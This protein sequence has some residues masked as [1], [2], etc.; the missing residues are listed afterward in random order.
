MPNVCRSREPCTLFCRVLCSAEELLQRFWRLTW[1]RLG[2][3]VED[4]I[5]LASPLHQSCTEILLI[6]QN[7]VDH[8]RPRREAS[9][10]AR[11]FLMYLLPPLP[12]HSHWRSCLAHPSRN[13]SLPGKGSRVGLCIVLFDA[14]RRSFTLIPASFAFVVASRRSSVV[15]IRIQFFADVPRRRASRTANSGDRA[16]FSWS[17]SDTDRRLTPSR[18]AS[19]V[20]VIGECGQHLLAQDS[21]RMGG[22]AVRVLQASPQW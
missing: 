12:R 7:P 10:V 21:V 4:H 20:C 8:P 18:C 15:C 14:A 22:P 6:D 1:R 11:A 3:S 5:A 16:R 2:G 17:N 19:S 9:C 13:I